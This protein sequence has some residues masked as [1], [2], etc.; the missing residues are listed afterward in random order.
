LLSQ[1]AK[2][3]KFCPNRV[4]GILPICDSN[5]E[6]ILPAAGITSI[7]NVNNFQHMI[8]R[9]Q[10]GKNVRRAKYLID[11][12]L[13]S[14]VNK[15]KTLSVLSALA[16][17]IKGDYMESENNNDH[18]ISLDLVDI[19]EPLPYEA[20]VGEI[21]EELTQIWSEVLKIEKIDRNDNFFEL[22]GNSLQASRIINAIYEVF[23][24]E[25]PVRTIFELQTVKAVAQKIEDTYDEVLG[26]EMDEGVI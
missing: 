26:G 11:P 10:F 16:V 2:F 23:G 18:D 17:Q 24:M 14:R 7:D 8:T 9:W 4:T 5:K 15:S 22:G 20:P 13:S 25:L 19:K 21:E 12:D 1:D 6:C 3:A